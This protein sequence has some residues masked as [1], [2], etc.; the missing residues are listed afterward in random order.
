D[1]GAVGTD[2][3]IALAALDAADGELLLHAELEPE[4]LRQRLDRNLAG[5]V[6]L[7]GARLGPLPERLGQCDFG[8]GRT[9]LRGRKIWLI[10]H[11]LGRP[12]PLFRPN[13]AS[14]IPVPGRRWARFGHLGGSVPDG[15]SHQARK[16]VNG[17]R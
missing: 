6:R 14:W 5:L 12:A 17:Y 1:V 7:E 8:T 16:R 4:L 11:D 13:A 10:R 2:E 15:E 3:G 9:R